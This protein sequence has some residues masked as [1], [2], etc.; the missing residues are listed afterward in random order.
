MFGA[1]VRAAA[2][3]SPVLPGL[4]DDREE[5]RGDEGMM[6]ACGSD[7]GNE[8]DQGNPVDQGDDRA[9]FRRRSQCR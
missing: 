5:E 4:G 3:A 1:P 7:V 6:A 9:E 2:R 8:C